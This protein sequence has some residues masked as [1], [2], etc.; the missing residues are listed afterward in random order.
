MK[1]Y[2]YNKRGWFTLVE[3]LIATS[4]LIFVS[5]FSF[6][7]YNT[8]NTWGSEEIRAAYTVMSNNVEWLLHRAVTGYSNVWESEWVRDDINLLPQKY[9]AFFR[10]TSTNTDTSWTY[11]TL[12]VQ[13]RRNSFWTNFTRIISKEEH[14]IQFPWIYVANIIWKA[15]S[16]DA[17]TSLNNIAI[18]FS[19]PIG[20]I[21]FF[22]NNL[23]YVQEGSI[24]I[25][26]DE[27]H[28]INEFLAPT[29]YLSY[30]IIEITFN[31]DKDTPVFIY[32]VHRDQ[33]FYVEEV[34]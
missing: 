9:V 13:N 31:W 15:N 19:N 29:D 12:E 8:M 3:T 28:T 30:N 5:W 23:F 7:F 24:M 1:S 6:S 32:K 33:Q 25:N 14:V 4:I 17:W 22:D 2:Q 26:E 21:E 11:Y 34:F 27:T 10:K 18:S 16:W 20:N